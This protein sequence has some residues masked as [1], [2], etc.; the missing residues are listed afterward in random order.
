MD[1]IYLKCEKCNLK[2]KV[3]RYDDSDSTVSILHSKTNGS[4]YNVDV[5][6]IDGINHFLCID[7][8]RKLSKQMKLFKKNWIEGKDRIVTLESNV[9][10]RIKSYNE[11]DAKYRNQASILKLCQYKLDQDKEV[12][13]GLEMEITEILPELK[14]ICNILNIKD[15]NKCAGNFN[16]SEK[17][18]CTKAK[19]LMGV[20]YCT[21]DYLGF[22]PSDKYLRR[23]MFDSKMKVETK[24]KVEKS[25]NTCKYEK[26]SSSEEPC[27]L[28]D[29]TTDVHNSWEPKD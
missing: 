10:D 11:L 20:N 7:C 17:I 13:N 22:I 18:S 28:C 3:H 21:S 16:S 5:Q 1:N 4:K 19:A 23:L 12:I 24:L 27:N 8:Y 15:C 2:F 26:L 9:Y 6:K 25:C 14:R 29:T